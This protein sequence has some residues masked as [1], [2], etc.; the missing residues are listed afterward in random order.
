M[1]WGPDGKHLPPAYSVLSGNPAWLQPPWP[2]AR[3]AAHLD[4]SLTPLATLLVSRA[5]MYADSP[6]DR[7]AHRREDAAWIESALG[8]P[9]T[10]FVPVWRSQSLMRG[11]AEGSAE[12][13]YVSG[14]AAA[15]LRIAGGAD[16][17]PWALLGL[18]GGVPVFVC[19]LS[20][21]EN[22]IPLLPSGLGEFADLRAAYPAGLR[23]NEAAILGHARGLMHWRARH[24]FCGVCGSACVPENAGNV[25]ACTGCGAKHF[26]RTD[27][28]VIMLVHRG[29]HVLLG[30][31][32]RFPPGMYS[33]LAGFV[34]PGESLEEAV[35]REVLE[36]TGIGV[37]AVTYESSQPWPFP[38]SI[39]LGFRAEALTEQIAC[40]PAELEDARWLS[41]AELT[42]PE[43]LGIQLP[44][45]DSIARRLIEDWIADA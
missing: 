9:G 4:R 10:L 35:R 3:V 24:G 26:P 5:N 7:A 1:F 28:A 36:E 43:A 6:L 20:E 37:G 40:D 27:P 34:E 25:L 42:D 18:L 23:P 14:E 32:A 8:D 39:M 16:G 13:V 21:A 31:S 29:E 11:V 12:A 45:R 44:R 30:H 17:A 22:P 19:D 33:T 41:R 2:R 15:A 38:S